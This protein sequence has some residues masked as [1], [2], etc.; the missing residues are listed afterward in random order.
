VILAEYLAFLIKGMRKADRAHQDRQSYAKK[1]FDA[2]MHTT[3]RETLKL[4]S[5]ERIVSECH[6]AR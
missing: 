1:F 5:L 2:K 4:N 3:L 6:P